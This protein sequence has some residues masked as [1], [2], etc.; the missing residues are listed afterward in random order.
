MILKATAE[1]TLG[2]ET[3]MP[4]AGLGTMGT[5]LVPDQTQPKGLK[6]C[7]VRDGSGN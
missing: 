5:D 4:R 1:G 3:V 2:L 6:M 7:S